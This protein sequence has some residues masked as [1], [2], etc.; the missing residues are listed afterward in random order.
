MPPEM[1]AENQIPPEKLVPVLQA[2]LE[3]ANELITFLRNR[4]GNVRAQVEARYEHELAE[5]SARI[6]DLENQLRD[7]R[8]SGTT[9]GD[10][11]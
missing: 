1:P 4:A 2:H 8:P 6:A 3:E 10:A 9:T 5:R 11:G 7:I